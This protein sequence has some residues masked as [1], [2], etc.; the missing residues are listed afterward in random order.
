MEYINKIPDWDG[1]KILI[2]RLDRLGD[3]IISTPIM[4]T[5]KNTYPNSQVDLLGSSLNCALN[6]YCNYIDNVYTYNKKKIF[7]NF[8]L[9][10]SLRAKKYDVVICLAP[11]SRS[12]N[13]FV[14]YINARVRVAVFEPP[15]ICKKFYTHS[16][17]AVQ[18]S[19]VAKF[20]QKSLEQMG[21]SVLSNLPIINVP[22]NII[23][24]VEANYPTN[25]KKMR[26]IISIGN[27]K[28]P[29]KRWDIKK[30][31]D[32]VKHLYEKY[33]KDEQLLDIF[34]MVGKSDLALLEE[35]TN[36]PKEYYTLYIGTDIGES[37]ALIDKSNLFICTSSGPSHIA[38]S[39]SC[40]ILSLL[41]PYMY[42]V[43]RPLRENDKCIVNEN[44]HDISVEE[45]VENIELYIKEWQ[46]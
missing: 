42:E 25:S 4:Q 3:L 46:Q 29:H 44:I 19:H 21:F 16:S 22:Q 39:T 37:A 34:L 40:P 9:L 20:Y 30:Y 35:F 45:V 17:L 38:A 36:A 23:D 2:I 14:K 18:E 10:L 6:N 33:N 41:N 31:S 12:A 43:W 11:Q 27:I 24:K 7:S 15:E 26:I 28:R 32:V 5:I 1:K 13:F 8:K